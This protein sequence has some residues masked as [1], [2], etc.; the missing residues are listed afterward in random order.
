M[1]HTGI[2]Y[3]HMYAIKDIF[4][5]IGQ[6]KSDNY[7]LVKHML[8]T[9]IPIPFTP[10]KATAVAPG[11]SMTTI[12]NTCK[13]PSIAIMANTMR[14]QLMAQTVIGAAL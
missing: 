4:P 5:Y 9:D 13:T 12:R 10:T 8:M 1:I 2:L 6:R 14:K 7:F 11:P 3:E